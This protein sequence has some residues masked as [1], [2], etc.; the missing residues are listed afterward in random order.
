MNA[1]LCPRSLTH[2]AG[3]SPL[4]SE[5]VWNPLK[6]TKTEAAGKCQPASH[7]FVLVTLEPE[8]GFGFPVAAAVYHNSYSPFFNLPEPECYLT[9]RARVDTTDD[10]NPTHNYP[11]NTKLQLCLTTNAYPSPPV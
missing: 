5:E 10:L 7:S 9:N 1:I 3:G 6:E 4:D 11:Q 8:T 2:L